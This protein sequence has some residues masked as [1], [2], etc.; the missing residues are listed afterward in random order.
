[1]TAPS[2]LIE[3]YRHRF[4]GS[5]WGGIE[6]ALF[7]LC[8]ALRELGTRVE[9][10]SDAE[11]PDAPAVDRRVREGAFDAVIPLIDGPL[12]QRSDPVLWPSLFRRVIRVWHDVTPLQP[13]YGAPV[14]CR[15]HVAENDP[16]APCVAAAVDPT[17]FRADVF[18]RDVPWAGCFPRAQ[19]IPWAG[20]HLPASDLRDP[21]GPVIIQVG[22]IDNAASLELIRAATR[23][24]ERVRL[25]FCNWTRMGRAAHAELGD[26]FAAGAVESFPRYDIVRDHP[27][28]FGGASAI[29]I[30]SR[31]HETFNFLAAESIQ[32]GIPVV[33]LAGS[34]ALEA[35][36]SAVVPDPGAMIELVR[37]GGHRGLGCRP[38]EPHS[39]RDVARR[40]RAMI[41]AEPPGGER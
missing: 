5:I 40:Y 1:V 6:T 19:T 15:R 14:P 23:A 7:H 36:A 27:R 25:V 31:Y 41:A 37:T 30:P 22:K 20:D 3:L 28:I 26:Q 9:V 12:F 18:L 16:E 33:A 10:Y 8:R 39:W 38:R 29:L 17:G 34:G 24:G 35:F 4:D 13:S 2:V 32:L 11:L 21:S